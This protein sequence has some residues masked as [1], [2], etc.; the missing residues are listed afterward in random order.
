MVV[1]YLFPIALGITGSEK[2]LKL[3]TGSCERTMTVVELLYT[4]VQG[5]ARPTGGKALH[6]RGGWGKRLAFPSDLKG[7]LLK[8]SRS[9]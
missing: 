8:L 3:F 6:Q 4:L 1:S 7:T 5:G 2:V 9:D